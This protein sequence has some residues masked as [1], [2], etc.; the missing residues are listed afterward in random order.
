MPK[1]KVKLHRHENDS[2]NELYKVIE[3]MEGEC[4]EKYFC[5]N[6]YGGGIWYFVSDPLGYCELDYACK[7]D[8]IFLVCDNSGSVLFEDGNGADINKAYPTPEKLSKITW[9]KIKNQYPT[10]E[11]LTNWLQSFIA[12]EVKETLK[13]EYCIYENWT[14]FWTIE[15][16]IDVIETFD[17]LGEK[18]NIYKVTKQHKYCSAEWVEYYTGEDGADHYTKYLGAWFDIT[19]HGTSYGRHEAEK[20]VEEAIKNIYDERFSVSSVITG[21]GMTQERKLKPYQAAEQLL[22]GNY[23]RKYVDGIIEQERNKKTFYKGITEIR[24]E[25]PDC[26]ADYSYRF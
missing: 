21:Y 19:A 14:V 16:S 12:A 18:Y 15:K 6:T 20:M 10:I 17:Y 1:I 24:K 22:K 23:D 3:V 2:Y 13:N 26:M 4:K 5:R 7:D 11:G 9:G 8:Y 25:H